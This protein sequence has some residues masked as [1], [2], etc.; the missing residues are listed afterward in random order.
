MHSRRKKITALGAV[1][2][3]VILVTIGLFVWHYQKEKQLYKTGIIESENGNI[4]S[5]ENIII[6]HKSQQEKLLA[7]D[8]SS[9]IIKNELSNFL[10]INE[11][12]IK[13]KI[14][15]NSNIINN[16]LK[17]N[18]FFNTAK[19]GAMNIVTIYDDAL[20]DKISKPYIMNSDAIYRGA[21]KD[22]LADA[23]LF[24]GPSLYSLNLKSLFALNKICMFSSHAN[25]ESASF[26]KLVSDINNLKMH[27]KEGIEKI[28][29]SI[30]KEKSNQPISVFIPDGSQPN[31][32]SFYIF[33]HIPNGGGNYNQIF[34]ASQSSMYQNHF[35]II[36]RPSEYDKY[37]KIRGIMT[38][39]TGYKHSIEYLPIVSEECHFGNCV[40]NTEVHKAYVISRLRLAG[41]ENDE[42]N[43]YNAE[44]QQY[45]HKLKILRG[46]L[47]YDNALGCPYPSSG[48]KL[49]SVCPS[50]SGETTA[51][52]D[53]SYSETPDAAYFEIDVS[54]I[55]ADVTF[56][57]NSKKHG[58][59][60]TLVY[61][62][63]KKQYFYEG[64]INNFCNGNLTVKNF[65]GYEFYN[66]IIKTN[67]DTSRSYGQHNEWLQYIVVNKNFYP[68]KIPQAGS[69]AV[70]GE[71]N[72][73]GSQTF[74]TWIMNIKDSGTFVFTSSTMGMFPGYSH[75]IIYRIIHGMLYKVTTLNGMISLRF[76]SDA[77]V[78]GGYV[79]APGMDMAQGT[80]SAIIS[81]MWDNKE[82]KFIPAYTESNVN[83]LFY[84]KMH[85]KYMNTMIKPDD[86]TE[87]SALISP[88]SFS[89]A[90]NVKQNPST[91]TSNSIAKAVN[92]ENKIVSF[93]S[94]HNELTAMTEKIGKIYSNDIS[95][96]APQN[97]QQLKTSEI[98]WI[99]E[100]RKKCGSYN[101]VI[102]SHNDS[103]LRCLIDETR[104][105]IK[106]LQ[107]VM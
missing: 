34:T 31:K 65:K 87:V 35:Y 2:F 66:K 17:T 38:Y 44:M 79:R 102:K 58:S 97:S 39:Y 21:K 75:V 77:L 88:D 69:V 30:N 85:L 54:K 7:T 59:K 101:S 45:K 84:A 18:G 52:N 92:S 10:A 20:Y 61:S 78:I 24:S 96:D 12:A 28:N 82:N 80:E 48:N 42:K 106:Y 27:Y 14:H 36:L 3:M 40:K 71:D 56:A 41:K 83:R 49:S 15:P 33:D 73:D 74:R 76:S 60:I 62:F 8:L 13:E 89:E 70:C 9:L 6:K 37:K 55:A 22:L 63:P 53:L 90:R 32:I 86:I 23:E 103:S 43:R 81:L 104:S 47:A 4:P 105:R 72:N 68:L 94:L 51:E 99:I 26:K 5:A 57:L 98:K 11:W 29:S 1:V 16:S 93:V 19:I 67:S 50:I 64:S 46:Q 95:Q 107:S 100:K 91:H 25:T